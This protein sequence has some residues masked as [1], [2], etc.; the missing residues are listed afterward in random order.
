MKILLKDSLGRYLL[1]ALVAASCSGGQQANRRQMRESPVPPPLSRPAP[2][3]EA[4]VFTEDFL[5]NTDWDAAARMEIDGEPEVAGA[6]AA[7]DAPPTL[8]AIG[9]TPTVT[10]PTPAPPPPPPVTRPAP[11]P[12]PAPRPAPAPAP[13]PAAASAAAVDSVCRAGETLR[14]MRGEVYACCPDNDPSE[15]YNPCEV[16]EH[17]RRMSSG[18]IA[19]CPPGGA[20]C[21]PPVR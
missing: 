20:H 14:Q 21:F 12:P 6:P 17:A 3:A 4:P 18:G 1:I 2:V 7:L 10:R 13:R 8:A 11:T 19:C 15:C 16:G 9:H 5:R